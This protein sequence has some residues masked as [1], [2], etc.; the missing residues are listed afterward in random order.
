MQVVPVLHELAPETLSP[1]DHQGNVA[2]HCAAE[3]GHAE[4][5]KVLLQYNAFI[6]AAEEDGWTPLHW[7]ARKGDARGE[8]T[9]A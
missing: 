7:A 1:L 8:E 6:N 3:N 4:V 2:A 5:V 9:H